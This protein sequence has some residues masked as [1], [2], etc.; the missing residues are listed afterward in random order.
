MIFRSIAEKLG[1][2]SDKVD[3]LYR[4]QSYA[5]LGRNDCETTIKLKKA[6]EVSE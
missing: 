3:E 6:K 1:Y 5:I 4:A 2:D